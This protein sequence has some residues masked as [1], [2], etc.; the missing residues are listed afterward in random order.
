[1]LDEIFQVMDAKW[2]ISNEV[3]N[4]DVFNDQRVMSVT[5]VGSQAFGDP[6]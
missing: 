2:V 6:K 4:R 5:R 3:P 1:M